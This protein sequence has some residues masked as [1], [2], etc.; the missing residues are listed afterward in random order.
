VPARGRARQRF[1]DDDELRDDSRADDRRDVDLREPDDDRRDVDLR[2]PDDAR[3][4]VDLRE[5]DEERDADLRDD[6]LR[7][8]D[9]RLRDPADLRDGTFAPFSRASL[10]PMAIACLRLVTFRPE[11][12][13]SVPRFRRRIVDSTFFD[14]ALPYFAMRNLPGGRRYACKSRDGAS[15]GNEGNGITNGRTVVIRC[16]KPPRFASTHGKSG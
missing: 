3:R 16:L 5:P 12:L 15:G 8:D 1:F 6:V 13:L 14:A 7:D 10:S 2:E 4:D 11:P 9:L